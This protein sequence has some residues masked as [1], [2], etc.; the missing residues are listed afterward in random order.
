MNDRLGISRVGVLV[1]IGIVTL[2]AALLI[3]AIYRAREA[4]IRA[5][6][7]NNLRQ[8]GLA[9]QNYHDAY[10]AF[11]YGCIGNPDLPPSRRWSWYPHLFPFISDAIIPPI[12]FSTSSDDP[13]N[14]PLTYRGGVVGNL[15]STVTARLQAPFFILCPDAP[16]ETDTSQQALA[17]YV[18]MAGIGLDAPSLS[19]GDERAGIWG[20][21]RQTTRTQLEQ[22]AANTIWVIETASDRGSWLSGGPATVRPI[23]PGTEL[24]IGRGRQFGGFHSGGSMTLLADGSARFLSDSTTTSVFERMATITSERSAEQD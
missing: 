21:D 17:T 13:S 9:L 11:P 6:C 20:Y 10:D 7:R 18:G 5:E 16:T 8:I 19:A 3:P 24:P 12:D 4:A 23:I 1:V 14:L 2:A 15:S 22:G